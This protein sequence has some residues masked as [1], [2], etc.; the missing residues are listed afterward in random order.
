MHILVFISLLLTTCQELNECRSDYNGID[1]ET[2]LE[3]FLKKYEKSDCKTLTPYLASAT[4]MKAQ[5]SLNPVKKLNFFNKGKSSLEA[6]IKKHPLSVDARYVRIMIQSTIPKFLNY[7]SDIKNDII[8]VRSNI[9]NTDMSSD[10]KKTMLQNI[11]N[12]TNRI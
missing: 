2:K 5:Y 11:N 6:Y 3:A 10:M 7:N 8:F 4:M 1:T 12:V 9:N